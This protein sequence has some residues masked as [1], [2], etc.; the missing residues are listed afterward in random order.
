MQPGKIAPVTFWTADK[1]T[2]EQR[3][4]FAVCVRIVPDECAASYT[5]E[6]SLSTHVITP[7]GQ[8]TNPPF[9]T[10]KRTHPFAFVLCGFKPLIGRPNRP[11]GHIGTGEFI[12]S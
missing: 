8:S 3:Y 9:A 10:K 1:Y 12:E 7:F 5:R 6:R 11:F 2:R 4:F